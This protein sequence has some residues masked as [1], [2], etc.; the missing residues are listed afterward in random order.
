VA[1]RLDV[2]RAALTGAAMIF[3][4]LPS[5]SRQPV[6]KILSD[7]HKAVLA[8]TDFF[9]SGSADCDMETQQWHMVHHQLVEWFFS[10][11]RQDPLA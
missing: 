9:T 3:G 8:A 4:R 6:G 7:A 5:G 10:L 1:Q 11:I 2:S